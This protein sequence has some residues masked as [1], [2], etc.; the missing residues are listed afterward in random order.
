MKARLVATIA[1]AGVAI[2]AAPKRH[3]P[4]SNPTAAIFA[5]ARTAVADAFKD[6]ASAQFRAL[7]VATDANGL[8]K[9]C[10]QV[11]A[12]N[13]YGGYVGFRPFAYLLEIGDAVFAPEDDDDA[14]DRN[15]ANR[16]GSGCP[17]FGDW[18]R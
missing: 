17:G 16:A 7:S 1:L 15:T 5:R 9:V 14:A 2:S 6:P 12:K 18:H 13:S 11:N 4:A 10:G 3:A 8:K